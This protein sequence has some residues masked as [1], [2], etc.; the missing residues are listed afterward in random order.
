MLL[1][2][3]LDQFHQCNDRADRSVCEIIAPIIRCNSMSSETILSALAVRRN[4][5][6]SILAARL[7]LIRFT[8]FSSIV[9]A[10]GSEKPTPVVCLTNLCVSNAVAWVI[11]QV[12]DGIYI[13]SLSWPD[14]GEWSF[15]KP[16]QLPMIYDNF[17]ETSSH[18]RTTHRIDCIHCDDPC[19]AA[20]RPCLRHFGRH[21]HF[22]PV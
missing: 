5:S 13:A 3:N 6:I 14:L 1:N 18:P 19:L 8:G 7:W 12:A 16:Y 22:R 4:C 10:R 17:G 21:R 20:R 9:L 15:Q 2:R 11:I